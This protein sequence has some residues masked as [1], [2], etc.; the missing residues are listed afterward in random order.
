MKKKKNCKFVVAQI[1]SPA[2]LGMQDIAKLGLISI[3]YDTTHRQ[4]A[5]DDSIDNS[6]S[7]R[8]TEGGKCE[9]FKGQK[10]DAETQSTQ[11]A[12]NTPKPPIVTNPMV[13]GNNYNS[14]D[15][16]ED[17]IANTR[18]NGSI[19][20]RSELLSNHSLVSD[21]ER[22]NDTKTKNTQIN[23][24]TINCISEPLINHS[25]VSE[26]EKKDDTTMENTKINTNEHESFI[27]DILKDI[28]MEAPTPQKKKKRK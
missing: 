2:V 15:L 5:E 13:I 10:Q 14:N 12:Y 26:E 28:G 7:P 1:G 19:D 16:I 23:C 21:E 6:E 8:Q 25:F 20:F 3:N 18:N 11:D 27:S 22:K 4:V 24:D 9:Q 17:L